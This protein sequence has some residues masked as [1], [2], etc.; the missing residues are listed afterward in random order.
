VRVVL[1]SVSV[2]RR[3]IGADRLSGRGGALGGRSQ[4]T[5]ISV[6]AATTEDVEVEPAD[7]LENTQSRREE[8]EELN[9]T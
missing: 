4:S 3:G 9:D 5:S 8:E 7:L 1:P 2:V 6:A